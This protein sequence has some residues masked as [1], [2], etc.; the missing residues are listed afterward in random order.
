MEDSTTKPSVV[1]RAVGQDRP[2]PEGRRVLVLYASRFGN[3]RRVAELLCT[4]LR[5]T[6]G[7]LVEDLSIDQVSFEALDQCDLLAVGGPTEI[8]SASKPMK[9]FL[10][11]LDGVRSRGRPAFAFETRLRSRLAGSAAK[12]IEKHLA[13][14]GWSI[15]RPYRTATVRGMTKEE[16]AQYGEVG[17][18]DWVQRI[19]ASQLG[20]VPPKPAELDLLLPG[21]EA[22]F[23]NLGEE[24]GRWLAAQPVPTPVGLAG[25][26][27]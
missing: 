2:R 20:T 1:E 17:A 23:E 9:A 27:V 18:P 11:R 12:Y 15:V 14:L 4:G 26:P 25:V 6:P 19:D 8:L 5:R 16:S 24:L 22:E 13:N 3:T 10:A 21:W 7:I